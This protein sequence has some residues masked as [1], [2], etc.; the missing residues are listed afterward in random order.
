MP[1]NEEQDIAKSQGNETKEMADKLE[2][3]ADDIINQMYHQED[4][5]DD[6]KTGD[7]AGAD[8][9]DAED[10]DEDDGDGSG[11]NDADDSDNDKT[12]EVDDKELDKV[13]KLEKRVRDTRSEFTKKSQELADTNRQMSTLQQTVIDLQTQMSD[14]A[15]A[16]QQTKAEEK[17]AEKAIEKNKV[18]LKDKL[19]AIRDVDED[20][21]NALEPLIGGLVSE[22]DT[23]K[24][25][26]ATNEQ[27]RQAKE[28]EDYNTNHYGK[29]DT[30]HKGWQ[31]MMETDDFKDYLDDLSP[32]DRRL[33]DMDLDGGTAE[34]VI[35]VFDAFK[36]TQKS[37]KNLTADEKKARKLEKANKMAGIKGNKSKDINTGSH[38][39]KFTR[40]EIAAMSPKE[41]AEKEPEIDQAMSDREVDLQN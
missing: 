28:I 37:E 21:A 17:K 2:S 41:Y 38:T 35:E 26:I 24:T 15:N 3:E 9:N 1:E 31:K 14:Q 36:V 6:D 40:S 22:V 33:A 13:K 29:L 8:D 11:D 27:A 18:D 7:N 32:R 16:T 5:A 30:A 4:D 10:K 25:T 12:D 23:L 39:F 19:S 20:L 34:Q